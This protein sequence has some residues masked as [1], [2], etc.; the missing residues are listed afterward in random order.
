MVTYP[1]ERVDAKTESGIRRIP[2]HS[3]IDA[4]LKDLKAESNDGYLLSGLSKN[5][6]GDRSNAI[7]KRFGHVKDNLGF[8]ARTE[9]FHSIRHTV[10]T[11]FQN[12]GVQEN[13][14]AQIVGHD[15]YTMTYGYYS[16]EIDL[17]VK[18]EALE[19]IS[20][21]FDVVQAAQ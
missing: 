6:Y 14:A 9:V 17:S 7:G 15:F 12:A 19:K 5:K 4:L 3:K 10:A 18:S 20:Y 2:I 16:K 11:K 21:G 13:I 8:E 1:W